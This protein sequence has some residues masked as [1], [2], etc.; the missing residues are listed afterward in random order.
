[1]KNRLIVLLGLLIVSLL[2][3]LYFGYSKYQLIEDKLAISQANNLAYATENSSYKGKN[4]VFQRT[5]SELK[6][7][8]D[9][10][11]KRIKFLIKESAIKSSK[12]KSLSYSLSL[13]KKSDTLRLKDTIFRE[14]VNVDTI[15]GDPM[16][17]TRLRLNYPNSISVETKVYSEKLV[18]MSE[19]KVYIEEPKK[20][21]ILRLFQ[22]KIK[23]GVVEIIEK[24][25]YIVNEKT[26]FINILK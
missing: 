24:N 21:F 3:S 1:M 5:I 4:I 23:I 26:R 6:Y 15:I 20:F 10:I 18:A 14:S 13:A 9:S 7:S 16:F 8:N 22:K 17:N 19:E 12:I 25:P 11:D 2:S